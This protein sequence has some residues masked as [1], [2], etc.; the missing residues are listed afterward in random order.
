MPSVQIPFDGF[1]GSL[2][3]GEL[4]SVGERTCEYE[5]ERQASAEYY[6]ETYVEPALRLTENEFAEILMRVTSYG[7][8]HDY[9]ARSYCETF[10]ALASETLETPLRLKF[11]EM[12]SPREYNFTTDRIFAEISLR[13]VHDLW[14]ISATDKHETL[15]RY[16][17]RRFTSYDGFLSHYSNDWTDWKAKPLRD[18]DHNEIGTLLLA[19]LE[20]KDAGQDEDALRWRIFEALSEGNEFDTALDQATD[21]PAF[22]A[23]VA[24]ARQDKADE[25]HEHDPDWI[26]APERC[27]KTPD[28]FA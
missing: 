5:T 17:G 6:P 12:T 11:E 28:L 15:R 4:D 25:E 7:A 27:D 20:V 24:E 22:E 18:W 8:A 23:A 10:S 26:P 21:W 3:S 14:R 13:A 2:W 9:I 16:I 19:A 1:Y